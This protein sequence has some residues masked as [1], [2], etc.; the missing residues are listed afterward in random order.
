MRGAVR[1]RR[2]RRAGRQRRRKAR[3]RA[4]GLAQQRVDIERD[5]RHFR[6]CQKLSCTFYRASTIVSYEHT[7]RSFKKVIYTCSRTLDVATT[8]TSFRTL[9]SAGS[10]DQV[11]RVAEDELRPKEHGARQQT[12]QRCGKEQPAPNCCFATLPI[13]CLRLSLRARLRFYRCRI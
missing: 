10:R 3:W 12:G 7:I 8:S 4:R 13:A 5:L 2:G 9:C 11:A 1:A 6:S